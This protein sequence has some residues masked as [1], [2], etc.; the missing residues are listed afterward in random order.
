MKIFLA[1]LFLVPFNLFAE[2]FEKKF[3]K[4]IEL[5]NIDDFTDKKWITVTTANKDKDAFTVRWFEGNIFDLAFI[6]T[7]D[8]KCKKYHESS[9]TVLFRVDKNEVFE[10]QM[11][12]QPGEKSDIYMID[13][14]N[15]MKSGEGSADVPTEIRYVT[16][17]DELKKGKTLRIRVSD[18]NNDCYKDLTIDLKNFDK[19]I[20]NL[21]D[22]VMGITSIAEIQEFLEDSID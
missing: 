8:E 21:S 12:K 7:S 22:E 18:N 6:I 4:W 10:M 3:G 16:Y 9:T 17:L 2:Q 1:L 5:I 19:A 20:K 15:W 14:K 11:I 13:F